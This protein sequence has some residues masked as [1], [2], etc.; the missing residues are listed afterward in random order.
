VTQANTNPELQKVQETETPK[1]AAL[2]DAKF[3]N[4][5]LFTRVEVVYQKRNA[6]GLAAE[7]RRLVE[8]TWQS[9][10]RAGAQLSQPDRV[11]MKQIN[12]QMAV[13]SNAFRRKLLAA[14]RGAAFHTDDRA[15]LAGARL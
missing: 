1:L 13:L 8:L 2:Q 9:F 12:E 4:P 3:L 7:S 15:A 10:T 5:K 14:A 11:R 6:A